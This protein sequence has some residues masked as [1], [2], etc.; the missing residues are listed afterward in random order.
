L[1]EKKKGNEHNS[2]DKKCE[3]KPHYE[4]TDDAINDAYLLSDLRKPAQMITKTDE[5]GQ[6]QKKTKYKKLSP[7]LFVKI[8]YTTGKKNRKTKTK[9]V[10]ALVDTG[11]SASIVTFKSAKGLPRNKKT[12]TKKWSTAAGVLNTSA[13]TKRLQ[14]SLPELQSARKKEKSFHVL[15]IE[16][17][18]YAMT[19]G[20]DLITSLQLDVKGSDMLIKW[21][22]AAIPW[23]NIDST[24]E[25]ICLAED[26]QSYH[27]V[28]Q[29]MNRM[30]G[31]LDAK[32]SKA[33]L[34]EVAQ[35]ADHLTTSEQQKLLAL[36]KKYEDLFDGTLGT[37]TG[38]PYDIKLKDN[39][40]PHHG[41]PFPVPKIHELTLKS[42]LDRLCELNMLKRVNR[43]QWGA[44]TFIIPKMD[45]T[46]RFISDFRELNKRIK[47]QP[48]PIP[49]IQNL[50]LK[51]EGFKCGTALD[52][53][54]GYY[55][56]ELSDASKELCAISTQWGKYE[57]QR[58]PMS[59]C[60]SP[61]IFQEKMND[62]LDG[63]DT[64]RVYIDDILHVTKG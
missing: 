12:E 61:D 17:K 14:F 15:D 7:I 53:N 57:H 64:V 47:R 2:K 9:I 36:L 58:P 5:E 34:N 1:L 23:R 60:N 39:V 33:D 54:M 55:H 43:S 10:K 21:D 16:L 63:L 22:D 49:K 28:E 8:E 59:L 26:N 27:P 44:P 52:L 24:V 50:L 56:I 6:T 37:F 4:H 30:N 19:I 13:K 35:S 18:N 25:D 3:N 62:L 20:R 41:R 11:A 32:Y 48:H 31:I 29:E 45:G 38:A 51:L 42:E 46:A 40:E